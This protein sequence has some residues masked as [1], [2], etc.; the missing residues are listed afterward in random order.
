MTVPAEDNGA[1]LQYPVF[2]TQEYNNPQFDWNTFSTILTTPWKQN[3]P[4]SKVILQ[5]PR[6]VRG[7]LL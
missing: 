5:N 3:Q 2:S 6:N 7:Q 4:K 1:E